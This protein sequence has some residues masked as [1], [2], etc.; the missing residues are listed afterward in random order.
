MHLANQ[1]VWL[2]GHL[3]ERPN[4]PAY[5][6]EKGGKLIRTRAYAQHE[7][8]Q[9]TKGSIIIDKKGDAKATLKRS[10][11]GICIQNHGFSQVLQKPDSERRKW[12]ADYSEW[13]N[14]SLNQLNCRPLSSEEAPKTGFEADFDL[15]NAATAN[16][17]RLFY[18][19]FAHYTITDVNLPD[20]KRKTNIRIPFGFTDVDSLHIVFPKNHTPEKTPKDID[21]QTPYGTYSRR[22]LP[23]EDG[24]L[25]IRKFTLNKGEYPPQEYPG[26]RAFFKQVQKHDKQKMVVIE[27]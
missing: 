3:Y 22:I 7:N 14:L 1:P 11:A 23:D 20:Q 17:N 25:F 18:A 5:D 27:R 19:P 8:R 26:F 9:T 4:R 16:A 15:Q 10:Y 2:F 6:G 21:L 13:G 24:F 12:L